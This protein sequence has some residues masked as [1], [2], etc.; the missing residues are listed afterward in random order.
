VIRLCPHRLSADNLAILV[1]LVPVPG[2]FVPTGIEL[3]NYYAAQGL[4]GTTNSLVEECYEI[5]A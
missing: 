2:Q 5:I 3:K 1:I 4:T